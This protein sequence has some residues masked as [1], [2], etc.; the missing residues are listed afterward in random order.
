MRKASRALLDWTGK[1]ARPRT[2]KLD[3]RGRLYPH[4]S[5]F[6]DAQKRLFGMKGK[7]TRSHFTSRFQFSRDKVLN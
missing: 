4:G 6:V 1:S 2:S 3:S 7:I 5:S